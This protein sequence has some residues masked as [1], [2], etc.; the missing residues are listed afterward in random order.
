MEKRKE[1][2]KGRE[3]ARTWFK[4]GYQVTHILKVNDI[5]K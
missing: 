4:N 2:E 1:K 5:N 3:R